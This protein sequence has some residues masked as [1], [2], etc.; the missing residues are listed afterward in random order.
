MLLAHKNV[1]VNLPCQQ[2]GESALFRAC[3]TR[4]IGIATALLQH[5]YIDIELALTKLA[6]TPEARA[7]NIRHRDMVKSILR[8]PDFLGFVQVSLLGTNQC[9]YLKVEC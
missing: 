1:N 3:S 2:D 5:P 7:A 8:H 4:N 9:I 6:T